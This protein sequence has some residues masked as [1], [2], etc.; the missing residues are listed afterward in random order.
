MEDRRN[1]NKAEAS[2]SLSTGE[3]VIALATNGRARFRPGAFVFG[4][5]GLPRD[6]RGG[7]CYVSAP[8]ESNGRR[9]L[10]TMKS[11]RIQ[12]PAGTSS[13][14]APRVTKITSDNKVIYE[15][16]DVI[17]SPIVKKHFERLLELEKQGKLTPSSNDP[18]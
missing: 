3:R 15:T 2:S 16:P 1:G 4:A 7:G 12:S 10:G 14:T 13:L 8:V 9:R 11:L 6:A 18:A 5:G 17:N